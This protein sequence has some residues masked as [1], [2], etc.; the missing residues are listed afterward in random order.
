MR[1]LSRVELLSLLMENAV[2]TVIRPITP[3]AVM[4]CGWYMNSD[5][6]DAKQ[7][8]RQRQRRRDR[9]SI[10]H[11]YS[12]APQSAVKRREEEGREASNE[13]YLRKKDD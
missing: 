1:A 7:R 11:A 3:S 8:Q 10:Q 12:T 2:M 6:D 9:V 4:V 13:I 5:R